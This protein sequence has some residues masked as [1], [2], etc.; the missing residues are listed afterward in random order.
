[1]FAVIASAISFQAL[2]WGQTGHRVSG[3]I[4]E[5]YLTPKAQAAINELLVNEDLAEVSTYPDEMRSNPSEF[6]QKTAN[7]WHYVNIHEGKKYDDLGAPPEGDAVTALEMFS[8]QLINKQTSLEDKQLALKFIV[9]IIGDLHQP[10]HSGT[11]ID[12][13]GNKIKV[14]FFWEDSN[15]HR[16]WDSGLIDRQKLS[17]TEWT[18]RLNR[19]ISAQQAKDWME[20]NPKVWLAESTKLR[21]GLYPE[22]D[23]L[24]W[25]YQYQNL[26]IVK[27]RLQ[28]AGVRIAAYLN[29]LYK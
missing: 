10:F 11:D 24:S 7:P 15:I 23:E 21:A 25:S 22:K 19:K 28:M 5:R 13:G 26:P 17:Y 1:M 8:K 27:Q 9:H 6:W 12:H 3:A 14:N 29:E 20:T 16:V 18:I 4:A 2:G